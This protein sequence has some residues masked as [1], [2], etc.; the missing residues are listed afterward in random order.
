M[1]SIV[2]SKIWTLNK[3]DGCLDVLV[4]L[5]ACFARDR[6]LVGVFEPDVMKA[7][8]ASACQLIHLCPPSERYDSGHIVRGLPIFGHSRCW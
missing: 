4:A 2:W 8:L 7:T 3:R 1:E 6:R 5:K